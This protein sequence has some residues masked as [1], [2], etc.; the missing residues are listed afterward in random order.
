MVIEYMEVN[1]SS[2]YS[3]KEEFRNGTQLFVRLLC[4][5]LEKEDERA[6]MYAQIYAEACM[7]ISALRETNVYKE[8]IN[9]LLAE[10][11]NYYTLT[12]FSDK[13]VPV[14]SSICL[15]CVAACG[16]VVA[17][18]KVNIVVPEKEIRELS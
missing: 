3:S 10:T 17:A 11:F 7:L 9:A 5:F 14:I 15:Y 4:E 8:I 1:E 18:Q 2:Q 6:C 13:L 12:Y 16:E